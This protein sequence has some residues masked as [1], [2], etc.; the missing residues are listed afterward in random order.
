MEP[1]KQ[2][3]ARISC[4]LAITTAAPDVRQD[5]P[6]S[7]CDLVSDDDDEGEEMESIPDE[8]DY[9][10]NLYDE[11]EVVHAMQE[12]RVEADEELV[13]ND[14][15]PIILDGAEVHLWGEINAS[16]SSPPNKSHPGSAPPSPSPN[17]LP[18]VPIPLIPPS[19]PSQ[20]RHLKEGSQPSIVSDTRY[21][22]PATFPEPSRV[23]GRF[24]LMGEVI[25]EFE[26]PIQWMQGTMVQ[27]FG[28]ALCRRTHFHPQRARRID[29][30]PSDLP[31]VLERLERGIEGDRIELET[32]IR[33][34]LQPDQCGMW[35]IPVCHRSH[36]WLI[37]VDWIHESVFVLDSFS[38]RGQDA[39]EVLTFAQTIVAK[40]HEVLEKPYAP[41]SRFSLDPVS[42]NVLGVSPSLSDHNQRLPRQTNS[43]DCGPHLAFDIACLAKSGQLSI[44]EESSVPTWRK[45]ILKQLRQL[46]VY[47]PKKPRLIV[48]SNDI[49]DLT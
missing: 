36:W 14:S 28:D 48:R 19:R 20:E 2:V 7:E 5:L 32:H 40:I 10:G 24:R 9:H 44:L 6:A 33:Q 4:E 16:L 27:V 8:T 35:L 38:S 23:S 1:V 34:C 26:N 30:L 45:V 47:D 31:T 49:I 11:Y 22:A 42:P 12:R 15:D 46:P 25:T 18:L 37:K 17:S 43:N 13:L 29:I 39:K 21:H 41:W 3:L